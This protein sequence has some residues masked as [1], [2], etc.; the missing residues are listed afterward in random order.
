MTPMTDRERLFRIARLLV[1]AGAE[2]R[3][4]F[5][6]VEVGFF[7][8][9]GAAGSAG[10]VFVKRLFRVGLEEVP[11]GS[12]RLCYAVR[13]GGELLYVRT[14]WGS[15]EAD[16][17]EDRFPAGFWDAV[18]CMVSRLPGAIFTLAG[19]GASVARSLLAEASR[20]HKEKP[21]RETLLLTR[22]LRKFIEEEASRRR[23]A[24]RKQ[25]REKR[26][27]YGEMLRLARTAPHSLNRLREAAEAV[28]VRKIAPGYWRVDA[29]IGAE[30]FSGWGRTPVS[31]AAE[32]LRFGA[33][34]LRRIGAEVAA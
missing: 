20:C 22:G 27:A 15:A 2:V 23:E 31:A 14:F 21:T 8:G 19:A 24:R 11:G 10:L 5:I 12:G 1:D 13:P 3:E 4:D 32:V 34:A 25:N 26:A 29:R 6:C 9:A 7:G 16:L 17:A 33:P 18:Y 28:R 30:E